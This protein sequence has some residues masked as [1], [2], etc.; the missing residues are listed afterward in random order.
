LVAHARIAHPT[1]TQTEAERNMNTSHWH[2]CLVC[3]PLFV[4]ACAATPQVIAVGPECHQ[5]AVRDALDRIRAKLPEVE[6]IL[7]DLE[8]AK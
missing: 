3:L 1:S 5:A 4:W 6:Q 7:K 2:R 8:D